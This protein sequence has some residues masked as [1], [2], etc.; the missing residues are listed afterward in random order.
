M[1]FDPDTFVLEVCERRRTLLLFECLKK[2]KKVSAMLASLQVITKC[3]I[4]QSDL[5]LP[6]RN[7]GC[8]T[9]NCVFELDNLKDHLFLASFDKDIIKEG[10]KCPLCKSTV[11]LED[12]FFD[13]DLAFYANQLNQKLV[14]EFEVMPGQDIKNSFLYM[15]YNGKFYIESVTNTGKRTKKELTDVKPLAMAAQEQNEIKTLELSIKEC[16]NVITKS[17]RNFNILKG[18][19][20]NVS[21]RVYSDQLNNSIEDIVMNDVIIQKHTKLQANNIFSFLY[22]PNEAIPILD[23]YYP[24]LDKWHQVQVSDENLKVKIKNFESTVKVRNSSGS[25]FLIG[26]FE[27]GSIVINKKEYP[28]IITNRVFQLQIDVASK[29]CKA[30]EKAPMKY[31]RILHSACELKNLIYVV[32]GLDTD[33]ITM[34]DRHIDP[35]EV[36]DLLS[37]TWREIKPLNHSRCLATLCPISED[38]LMVVG[39]VRATSAKQPELSEV[40]QI[41]VLDLK[42]ETWSVFQVLELN[43]MQSIVLLN[44]SAGAFH[45]A[46]NNS[47]IIFGGKPVI[48]E[49][50][51]IRS[52]QI[53]NINNKVLLP[54]GHLPR[55]IRIDDQASSYNYAFHQTKVYICVK[56]SEGVI[57]YLE[58]DK[59]AQ[60]NLNWTLVEKDAKPD[61]SKKP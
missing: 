31:R 1:E 22:N 2:Q 58:Y 46:S 18:L 15:D 13:L 6:V 36:Y 49:K 43:K 5:V 44:H 55:D 16:Q 33:L 60:P 30:T 8:P 47:L 29:K 54:A 7:V 48:N 37:N 24:A 50:K 17:E 25:I 59:L 56:I 28:K 39:G 34:L 40:T 9:T 14:S 52:T 42:T 53:F 21:A 26:G 23:L 11:R 20:K 38:K 4:T 27:K 12:Y 41:E 51:A 61:T 19:Y 57:G 32:G 35:C 3:Q 10:A 45:D